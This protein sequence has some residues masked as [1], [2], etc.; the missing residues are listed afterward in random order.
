MDGKQLLHTFPLN[1]ETKNQT[2]FDASLA[3]ILFQFNSSY[4]TKERER[5]ESYLHST[6]Q[7]K[8]YMVHRTI[9][10]R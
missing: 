2:A 9:T 8:K 4:V 1:F 7:C 10:S 6:Y 3:K 5:V